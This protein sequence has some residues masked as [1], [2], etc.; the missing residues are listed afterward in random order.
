MWPA[1]IIF[2]HLMC[3]IIE[4]KEH[5]SSLFLKARVLWHGIEEN[6][7]HNQSIS[8]TSSFLLGD[9]LLPTEYLQ[10]STAVIISLKHPFFFGIKG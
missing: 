7:K 4:N 5:G 9:L 8:G 10:L 3:D 1:G 6:E 2:R